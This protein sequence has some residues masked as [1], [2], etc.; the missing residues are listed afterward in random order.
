MLAH[1]KK[2]VEYNQDTIAINPRSDKLITSVKAAIEK[3][4]GGLDK[5]V[6]YMN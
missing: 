6:I 4:E 5:E 2:I 1:A 3:G